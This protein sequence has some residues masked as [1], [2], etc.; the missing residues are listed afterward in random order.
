MS[1]ADAWRVYS[2]KGAPNAPVT[3]IIIARDKE[4]SI[5]DLFFVQWEV[6]SS[7]DN[8]NRGERPAPEERT[9]EMKRE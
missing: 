2:P 4:D 6:L 9:Y 1:V 5:V 3:S 8:K 7:V